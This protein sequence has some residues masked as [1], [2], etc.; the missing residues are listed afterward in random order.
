V[1]LYACKPFYAEKLGFPDSAAIVLSC[2]IVFW[3]VHDWV[4]EKQIIAFLQNRYDN[5]Y[6][7]VLDNT[8]ANPSA[9]D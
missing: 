3:G 2:Q 8:G 5:R 9:G 4:G 1:A 7:R 6:R